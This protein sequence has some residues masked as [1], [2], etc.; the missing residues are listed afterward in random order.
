MTKEIDLLELLT[1]RAELI[2]IYKATR[3]II[4]FDGSPQEKALNKL[5]RLITKLK[6]MTE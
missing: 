3:R 2:D 5:D 4:E 6:K 1:T